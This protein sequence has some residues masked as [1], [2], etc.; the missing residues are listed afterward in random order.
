MRMWVWS[1]GLLSGLRI[2]RYHE[3][4]CRL[5]A[6]AL[7]W[8]LAWELPYAAGASLKKQK[9]NQNKKTKKKPKATVIKT[10]W[11]WYKNRH[12][13][14][15]NRIE[16]PEINPDTYGQLSFNKGGKS[17]KW[18]K[19]SLFSNWCWENWTSACKS[20]KL[21]HILKPCA[22][23]NSKWLKDQNMTP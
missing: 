4:P 22:K 21:E 7:I 11:Y 14:Q 12:M 13:E 10:L 5:G 19:D 9:P 23:R 6:A 3:L 15:W 20:I 16:H 18:E 8:P 2:W 17:I 1:L